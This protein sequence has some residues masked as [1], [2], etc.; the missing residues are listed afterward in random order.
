MPVHTQSRGQSVQ[1]V[2]VSV[3]GHGWSSDLGKRRA[4]GENDILQGTPLARKLV[5]LEEAEE[6]RGGG[7]LWSHVL[8]V[9]YSLEDSVYLFPA[10]GQGTLCP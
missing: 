3:S 9:F 10:D 4:T 2:I 8:S 7:V 5:R 1:M 6:A